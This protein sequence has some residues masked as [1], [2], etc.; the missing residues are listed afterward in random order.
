MVHPSSTSQRPARSSGASSSTRKRGSTQSI[1]EKAAKGTGKTVGRAMAS[2]PHQIT[3]FEY[4][5]AIGVS[6]LPE[7]S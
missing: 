7:A 3:I 1:G 2:L 5:A 4:A 6:L